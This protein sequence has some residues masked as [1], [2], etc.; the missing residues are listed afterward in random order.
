MKLL[1]A[2]LRFLETCLACEVKSNRLLSI[3]YGL[4]FFAIS[5]AALVFVVKI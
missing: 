4:A 2:V 5:L 3:V 1:T